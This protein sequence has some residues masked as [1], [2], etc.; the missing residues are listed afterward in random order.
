MTDRLEEENR[1]SSAR[2]EAAW[3]EARERVAARN[4]QAQKQGRARR[5]VFQRQRDDV[6]R[7]AEGRRHGQTPS[8]RRT[9]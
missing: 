7:A 1:S 8:G 4:Q 5:E 2:G 6:L 9:P 3:K